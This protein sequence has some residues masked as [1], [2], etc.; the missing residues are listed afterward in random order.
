MV[1]EIWSD[2]SELKTGIWMSSNALWLA[3][4]S[5]LPHVSVRK[6][7]LVWH[8]EEKI[9]RNEVEKLRH[10]WLIHNTCR[11][12]LLQL[13]F[14]DEQVNIWLYTC[15][16]N[17]DK[18]C[19]YPGNLP[20]CNF[21]V[22][23]VFSWSLIAGNLKVLHYGSNIYI[24]LIGRYFQTPVLWYSNQNVY[25]RSLEFT[26]RSANSSKI[27]SDSDLFSS[28]SEFQPT[29]IPSAI[30]SMTFYV[31][32]ILIKFYSHNTSGFSLFL[33]IP[34]PRRPY[35]LSRMEFPCST[36]LLVSKVPY[37]RQG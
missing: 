33:N 11:G 22:F 10:S 2:V 24:S 18:H 29:M 14:V 7:G 26:Y 13:K 27:F 36:F 5:Q 12:C 32:S 21:L 4:C 16:A 15:R 8:W 23:W 20:C 3:I 28:T 1:D 34:W 19:I 6:S 35:I 30:W 25:Y 37:E 17:I 9:R 31:S